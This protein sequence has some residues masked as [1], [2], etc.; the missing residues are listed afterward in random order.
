VSG[1]PAP[2]NRPAGSSSRAEQAWADPAARLTI[3]ATISLRIF[4]AA[5]EPLMVLGTDGAIIVANR[6]LLELTGLTL[7]NAVGRQLREIF[8]RADLRG[9][10]AELAHLANQRETSPFDFSFIDP[11]GTRRLLRVMLSPLSGE[12][13]RIVAVF[14][15]MSDMSGLRVSSNARLEDLLNGLHASVWEANAD[16]ID[17]VTFVNQPA[18]ALFG[19]SLEQLKDPEFSRSMILPEDRERMLAEYAQGVAAGRVFEVDYRVRRADGKIMWARD[20]VR[21][22]RARS[23][24]PLLRAIT[25]DIT[26]HKRA[27]E[28]LSILAE[29]GKKLDESLE[30]DATLKNV[31]SIIVPALADDCMILLTTDTGDLELVASAHAGSG[32]AAA[33]REILRQY[34]PLDRPHYPVYAVLKHGTPILV[35]DV[36]QD[37]L[38]ELA[39]EPNEL[40]ASASL[41]VRSGLAV[42]LKAR[43]AILGAMIWMIAESDRRYDQEDLK[44]A[45]EIAA[46]AALAVDNARLYR[47]AQEGV[48]A[49]DRFLAMLG[50]ELRNPLNAISLAANILQR[51]VGEERH[52][53]ARNLISRETRQLTKYVDDLLE[54]AH[55]VAGKLSLNRERL[56]LVAVVK[57]AAQSFEEHAAQR[58]VRL[59]LALPQAPLEVEG[60]P[61][62]IHQMLSN[63]LSNAL[64]FTKPDDRIELRLDN[65]GEFARIVVKDTG[66]GIERNMLEQIFEPF[67]QASHS[68]GLGLGLPLVRH[69]VQL[70]GG[71]VEAHSDGP[72]SGAEFTILL[73]MRSRVLDAI[74]PIKREQAGSPRPNP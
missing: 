39:R 27:Q 13:G 48:R 67:V 43:G 73:P 41:G 58:Q 69:V 12:D 15:S 17:E 57:G 35:R 61:V 72:G 37:V 5:H 62:R 22:S 60:D 20:I 40:E 49:R 42:P 63:L 11:A 23:G 52:A 45:E 6:A 28:R 51:D 31:T 50:H 74:A 3:D 59:S 25:L 30:Y 18:S 2:P 70:H 4:E 71:R 14:A 64:R 24:R 9:F 1:S 8:A 21:V 19:Y 66:I 68:D 46:R 65:D 26:A 47:S 36:T 32:R 44:L 38:R 53:R 16:P 10:E 33:I 7:E 29:A 54:L 34:N 56:D 55:V